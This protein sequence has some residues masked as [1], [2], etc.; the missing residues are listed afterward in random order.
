MRKINIKD[1]LFWIFFVIG[2]AMI[3]WKIFGN[4]PTDLQVVIP[5]IIMGFLK[6]WGM[7]ERMIKL[8]MKTK[9]GFYNMKRDMN[10][11]KQDLNL[12]KKGA[13]I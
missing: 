10:L 12:I 13:G 8:E 7:N 11:I 9:N 3:L 5:F 1:I 6:I 2:I 4:S